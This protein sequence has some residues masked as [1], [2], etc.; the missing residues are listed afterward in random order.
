[1]SQKW[2]KGY[3]YPKES[4][5]QGWWDVGGQAEVLDEERWI[6]TTTPPFLK[7]GQDEIGMKPQ[8]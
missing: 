5:R 1:M 6:K 8:L 2:G 4:E 7:Q 3:S